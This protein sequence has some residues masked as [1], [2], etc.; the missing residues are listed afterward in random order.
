MWVDPHPKPSYLFALVAGQLSCVEV[1]GGWMLR[2][3]VA[4]LCLPTCCTLL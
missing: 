2:L 3:A 1:G 4:S